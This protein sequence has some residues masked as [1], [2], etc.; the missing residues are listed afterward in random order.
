MQLVNMLSGWAKMPMADGI[1]LVPQEDRRPVVFAS[2]NAAVHCV[3]SASSCPKSSPACP[4]ITPRCKWGPL[5]RIVTHEGEHAGIL[6]LTAKTQDGGPAERTIGIVLG[7]DS[8]ALIDGA[9]IKPERFAE[10]RKMVQLITEGFFLGLGEHRRRRFQFQPPAAGAL[11]RVHTSRY[12]HPQYPREPAII[13][14]HDTR[15][16]NVTVSG[17]H[18]PSVVPGLHRG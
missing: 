4:S 3:A 11:G 6:T 5:Q 16:A 8:Y 7:D 17:S 13:T 1:V 12:Y 15:P 10:V 9:V 14:V 2:T 18:R